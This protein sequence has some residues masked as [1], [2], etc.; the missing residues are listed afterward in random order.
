MESTFTVTTFKNQT[1]IALYD[2]SV[3]TGA[4]DITTSQANRLNAEKIVDDSREWR[5]VMELTTQ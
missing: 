4:N 3:T 5:R 2:E 1:A